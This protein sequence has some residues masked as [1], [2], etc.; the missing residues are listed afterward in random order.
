M[1]FF[2]VSLTASYPTE[3]DYLPGSYSMY[4][5][6]SLELQQLFY[7]I[8][9]AFPWLHKHNLHYIRDLIEIFIT[10]SHIS[11]QTIDNYRN[12][13]YVTTPFILFVTLKQ[14]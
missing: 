2:C 12:K 5:S 10:V 1:K 4:Q 6:L 8:C 14:A 7:G 13:V 3:R 9:F 11:F